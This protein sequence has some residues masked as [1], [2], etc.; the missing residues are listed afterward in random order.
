MNLYD[1]IPFG[2]PHV[3]SAVAFA[4]AVKCQHGNTVRF[5]GTPAEQKVFNLL[6]E[7][8]ECPRT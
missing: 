4:E 7:L 3:A 5:S 2:R 6:T 1:I 8:F